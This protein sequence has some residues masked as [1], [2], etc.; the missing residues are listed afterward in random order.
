MSEVLQGPAQDNRS[1]V[2]VISTVYTFRTGPDDGNPENYEQRV[3]YEARCRFGCGA[4]FTPN[5]V[6]IVNYVNSHIVSNEHYLAKY[7]WL[8][9]E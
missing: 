3:K 1:E 8:N 2:E 6:E 9:R 4:H 7:D 5:V